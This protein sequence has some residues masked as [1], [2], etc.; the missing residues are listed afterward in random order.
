MNDSTLKGAFVR[1]IFDKMQ[2]DSRNRDK[3][4][5]AL[6]YGLRAFEGDVTVNEDY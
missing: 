4:M 1:R 5:R 6:L 3:Y 2:A